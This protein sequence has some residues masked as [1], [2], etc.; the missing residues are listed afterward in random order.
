MVWITTGLFFVHLVF[1]GLFLYIS[2]KDFGR[3]I[4]KTH[5]SKQL[6]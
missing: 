1:F 3:I 5:L 4:N 2:L 6:F